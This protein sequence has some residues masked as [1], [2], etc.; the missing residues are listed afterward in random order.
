VRSQAYAESN[1]LYLKLSTPHIVKILT[2]AMMDSLSDAHVS[3]SGIFLLSL[4]SKDS[5][6]ALALILRQN[7]NACC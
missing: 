4:V 6:V 3:G 1:A 2:G 7:R 5:S